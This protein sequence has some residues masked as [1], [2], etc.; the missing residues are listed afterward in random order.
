VILSF[1]IFQFFFG[2]GIQSNLVPFFCKR[3]IIGN[4]VLWYYLPWF[5]RSFKFSSSWEKIFG[6]I[7]FYDK[8]KFGSKFYTPLLSTIY[9]LCNVIFIIWDAIFTEGIFLILDQYSRPRYPIFE[10]CLIFLFLFCYLHLEENFLIC[11]SQ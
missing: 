6:F 7:S 9:C 11:F 8:S 10:K 3:N 1:Y 4:S 2:R 5:N